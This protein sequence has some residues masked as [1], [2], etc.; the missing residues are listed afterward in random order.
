MHIF[1]EETGG[2]INAIEDSLVRDKTER[3]VPSQ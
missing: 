1:Q 3:M 2:D